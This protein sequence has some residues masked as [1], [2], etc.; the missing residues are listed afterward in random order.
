MFIGLYV[1]Q[2]VDANVDAHLREF[3]VGEDLAFSIKPYL[4]PVGYAG[5]PQTQTGIRL[6][7]RFKK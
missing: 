5:Q 6:N 3:D 7:L 4:C 2:I 1:L